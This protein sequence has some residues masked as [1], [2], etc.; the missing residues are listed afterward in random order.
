M[1]AIETIASR[2]MFESAT[3]EVHV[4]IAEHA[5]AIYLDIGNDAWEAIEITKGG[6]AVV[7]EA[8]VRF[9]RAPSART[10]PIPER[11]G[12]IQALRQFCN[13]TDAGFTLFVAVLLAGLRPGSNYPV[14]VLTGE[15]GCG[16]S[17]LARILVHLVDP[18]MPEQR[19][20]P[21][22]EEDLLVAAKGQHALAFDNVSGLSDWLSDAFCRLS[23]GG[24]AGKRRLYTDE[25][26]VLF[27]GRRLVCLNGI[28]DVAVRGHAGIGAN[29]GQ[30]TARRRGISARTRPNCPQNTRCAARR[31]GH[32][33]A[34]Y[35]QRQDGQ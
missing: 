5:G 34:R 15:Q 24:G 1:V 18:R 30:P 17:S 32:R 35:Q 25:D 10:L 27:S 13:L 16:K 20:M 2:A 9:Q 31:R 7:A 22:S 26:E 3:R 8:P 33:A 29:C 14:P 21:R 4:R 28:E 19:S 11:G 23:T 12:S 6:W